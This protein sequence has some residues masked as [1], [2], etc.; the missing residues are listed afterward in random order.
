MTFR[1]YLQVH[2]ACE[3][4]HVYLQLVL[5]VLFHARFFLIAKYTDGYMTWEWTAKIRSYLYPAIFTLIYK[6]ADLMSMD[7]YATMVGHHTV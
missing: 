4:T 1:V 6:L 2:Y 7:N 5:A 3:H